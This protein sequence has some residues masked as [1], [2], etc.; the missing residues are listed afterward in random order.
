MRVPGDGSREPRCG[1][2]GY[3][4]AGGPKAGLAD[5]GT[6]GLTRLRGG[7]DGGGS[8]GNLLVRFGSGLASFERL[9]TGRVLIHSLLTDS[10]HAE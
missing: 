9:A 2:G 6:A 1:Y 3:S 5:V 10:I 7:G 4:R 8:P